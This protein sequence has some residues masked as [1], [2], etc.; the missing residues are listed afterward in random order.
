M[1]IKIIYLLLIGYLNLAGQTDTVKSYYENMSL[2]T[3]GYMIKN[4]RYE[5]I[6]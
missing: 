6:L 1:N 3:K 5:Y 2:K 4:K